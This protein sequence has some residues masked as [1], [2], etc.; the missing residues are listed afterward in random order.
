MITVQQKVGKLKSVTHFQ[1]RFI[2]EP[3]LFNGVGYTMHDAVYKCLPCRAYKFLLSQL[4]EETDLDTKKIFLGQ[5]MDKMDN[6][7][8]F[9]SQCDFMNGLAKRYNL[10]IRGRET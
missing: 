8:T 1:L 2:T 10:R 9:L 6:D 3:Q 4:I 5:A 7:D